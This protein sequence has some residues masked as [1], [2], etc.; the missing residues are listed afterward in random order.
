[1]DTLKRRKKQVTSL[2]WVIQVFPGITDQ[3]LGMFRN[4][5]HVELAFEKQEASVSLTYEEMF[6]EKGTNLVWS[7]E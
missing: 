3:H 1:M 6:L 4:M 7:K 5:S 2:R